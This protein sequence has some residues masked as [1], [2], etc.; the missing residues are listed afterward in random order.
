MAEALAFTVLVL[1]LLGWAAWGVGRQRSE[2]AM[3]S[4]YA[5]RRGWEFSVGGFLH[6]HTVAGLHDGGPVEVTADLRGARTQRVRYTRCTARLQTALPDGFAVSPRGVVHRLT[7]WIGGP[8]LRSGDAALDEAA[9]I[10]GRDEPLVR[11]LLGSEAMRAAALEVV[12]ADARIAEGCVSLSLIGLMAT[13]DDLD[14][15][16]VR[17][18]ELAR[19][20]EEAARGAGMDRR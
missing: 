7:G 13:E 6:R 4:A 20:V 9:V 3:W 15:L 1:I 17:T 16:I 11:R 12:M 19:G 14:A 10:F 5:G 2:K 8:E 18:R